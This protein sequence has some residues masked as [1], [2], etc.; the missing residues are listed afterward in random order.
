MGREGQKDKKLFQL[1]I[2]ALNKKVFCWIERR[3]FFHA[4]TVNENSY[5]QINGS[6][7]SDARA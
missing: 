5:S 4:Q 6:P 7:S 3:T 2:Q 1:D